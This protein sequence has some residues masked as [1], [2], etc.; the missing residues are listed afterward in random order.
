MKQASQSVDLG[1]GML[2]LRNV[3]FNEWSCAKLEIGLILSENF[4]N[5][6]TT[7]IA[8]HVLPSWFP[9]CFLL[10]CSTFAARLPKKDAACS[11]WFAFVPN[12]WRRV[13]VYL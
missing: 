6:F 8:S 4:V 11:G 13:L 5:G 10:R 3:F 2:K 9:C 1:R 7:S 12:A